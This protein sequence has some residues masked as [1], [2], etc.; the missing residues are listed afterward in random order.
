MEWLDE[1]KIR[2]DPPKRPK[3]ITGT[4]FASI[5]G[6]DRWTQIS[7]HGVLLLEHT[8]TFR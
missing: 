1:N 8:R 6:L 2:V 5:L 7:K 3:R 4:R